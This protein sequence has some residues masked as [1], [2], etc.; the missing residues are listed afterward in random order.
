MI[1]DENEDVQPQ[2]GA[3][4]EEAATETP[5]AEAPAAEAGDGWLGKIESILPD[6]AL[7]KAKQ[8]LDQDGDGNPINDLT[9]LAGRFFNKD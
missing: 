9:G 1:T 4:P 3:I 2:E 6:G 8:M 7:D 5:A